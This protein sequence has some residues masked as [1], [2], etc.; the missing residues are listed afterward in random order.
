MIGESSMHGL[1]HSF[2]RPSNPD[3]KIFKKFRLLE[4]SHAIHKYIHNW[5][6][7]LFSQDYG[8]ALILYVIC[9]T[10]SLT[11]TPN[12][13]FLRNFCMTGLFNSQSFCQKSAERKS[14]K[15]YYFNILFWCLA[16]NTN[17]DFMSNKPTH[18]LLDNG[19]FTQ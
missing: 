7:Q 8:L 18:H 14:P 1:W 4:T 16:W 19:D 10:Y 9:G 12:N 13:R 6:L 5:P 11:S 15:K 2:Y 3:C 17:P